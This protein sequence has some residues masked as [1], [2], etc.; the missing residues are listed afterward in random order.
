MREGVG[1]SIETEIVWLFIFHEVD[2]VGSKGDE[3]DLHDED[4]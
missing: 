3:D 4:V 2:G 1:F